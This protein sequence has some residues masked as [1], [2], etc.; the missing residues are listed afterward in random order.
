[1]NQ[2]NIE[3]CKTTGFWWVDRPYITSKESELPMIFRSDWGNLALQELWVQQHREYRVWRKKY[4]KKQ[5]NQKNKLENQNQGKKQEK[6]KKLR[7]MQVLPFFVFFV[8][9]WF[10]WFFSCFFL[11]LLVILP[12]DL[13]FWWFCF[14]L[15]IIFFVK[16]HF[17]CSTRGHNARER[18]KLNWD[19]RA[20]AEV[21]RFAHF[22]LE[23]GV[24]RANKH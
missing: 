9:F 4:L 12:V 24:F 22:F 1:M 6:Q 11:F 10:L 16:I 15:I 21:F 3:L 17:L 2:N 5:S 13:F 23:L 20:G 18:Q 8:C 19:Q 7:K 14:F